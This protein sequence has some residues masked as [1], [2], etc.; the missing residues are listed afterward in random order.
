MVAPVEVGEGGIALLV[1]MGT[2]SPLRYMKPRLCWA[3]PPDLNLG[4]TRSRAVEP[5]FVSWQDP[6]V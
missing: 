2:P 4:A 1:S 3:L 6:V 5:S